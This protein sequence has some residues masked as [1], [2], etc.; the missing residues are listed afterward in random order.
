MSKRDLK[1]IKKIVKTNEETLNN[2]ISR[3]VDERQCVAENCGNGNLRLY[4]C[5]SCDKSHPVCKS[6]FDQRTK[7][8]ICLACGEKSIRRRWTVPLP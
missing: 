7:S 1:K 8:Q 5:S 2:L 6:H 3:T 4:Y